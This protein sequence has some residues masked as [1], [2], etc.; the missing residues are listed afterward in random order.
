MD[1]HHE[2]GRE[3]AAATTQAPAIVPPVDVYEDENGITLKADLPGVAKESLAVHVEGDQLVI[4]GHV[5]LGESA[6]LEPVY[7]E[8]RV[9]HYRRTF[10]L[11]RDLDTARIEAAMK[12]GVLTLRVPKSEQARPRRIPVRIA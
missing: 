9:A 10:A 12:N 1:T 5:S 8:V 3:G 7:A 4:E 11:S 2:A 6:R